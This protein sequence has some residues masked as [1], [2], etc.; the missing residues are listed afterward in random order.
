MENENKNLSP[1][2]SAVKGI[3]TFSQDMA[4]AI[5][6]NDGGTIKKIIQE[7]EEKE[8]QNIN[9]SP[10]SQRNKLFMLFSVILIFLALFLVIFLLFFRNSI[11]TVNVITPAIPAIF[12]DQK[13]YLEIG[14]LEKEQI[15]SVIFNKVKNNDLKAGG[16]E[17]L[18]LTENKKPIGF[19]RLNIL[20]KSGISANLL[21]MTGDGFLLGFSNQNIVALPNLPEN[22]NLFILLKVK[23]FT[24]V[25]PE[26]RIWENKMFYDLHGF[27]GMDINADTNYLLTKNFEDGFM[28]NKNARIL[29]DKDGRIV[30]AYVFIDD[31]DILI[32]NDINTVH[33]IVLRL[34][35]SQIRK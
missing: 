25:F 19:K 10:E 12:T 17:S 28:A 31:Q 4:K 21:N 34:L 20:L 1:K 22:K 27:F 6:S 3:K 35:S 5:E 33:E 2:V 29:R 16:L 24:D 18:Y 13:E 32:S 8:N 30:L 14:G 26:F 15:S 11:F 23:S 9:S 7:Q